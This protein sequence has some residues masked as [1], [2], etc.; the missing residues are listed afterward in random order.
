MGTRDEI[1]SLLDQL[2]EDKLQSA[3]TVLNALLKPHPQ[4]P[5]AGRARERG[6]RFRKL[7][8]QQFHS[9]R[10]AGTISAMAGGG[11]LFPKDGE[12][13]GRNAFHYRDDKALVH[14]T[15]Q[16]FAGQ[17]L[18][19]MERMSCSEDGTMLTYEQELSSG[20]RRLRNKAEFPFIVAETPAEPQEP[21][22]GWG[23]KLL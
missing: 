14:Q 13:Y 8:E 9:T 20:G 16:F 21:S 17:E 3:L 18:E 10:K 15:L 5:E 6:R 2:P 4:P 1:R 11:G 22:P 7:V 19:I 23:K 12:T